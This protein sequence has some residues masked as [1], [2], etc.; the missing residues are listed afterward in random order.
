MTSGPVSSVLPTIGV[1]ETGRM[2]AMALEV[3]RTIGRYTV[4]DRLG[5]GGMGIVLRGR[6]PELD[7]PVAIK[8]ISRLPEGSA[9]G[10][11]IDR[12][13]REAR[14]AAVLTH[15]HIVT[16]YDVGRDLSGLPFIVME[17]LDGQSL[18]QVI[19]SRQSI[20][21]T[22]RLQWMVDL[23]TGLAYAHSRGVVHRDIKPANLMITRAG[24]LKIL[25]F[26]I[27]RL[28]D[29][30]TSQASL[31]Q[32]GAVLGTPRY[33]SPEQV[34]G[35]PA[36][37]RSDVFSVGVVLYELFTRRSTPDDGTGLPGAL[38]ARTD[39]PE[40][41]PELAPD[42]PAGFAS[43]VLK[44]L[45]P[46]P[47]RRYQSITQL[48]ADLRRWT[49]AFER[50]E[51]THTLV[52]APDGHRP[53]A[54]MD[55]DAMLGAFDARIGELLSD[56]SVE[57]AVAEDPA[58]M[59]AALALP[60]PAPPPPVKPRPHGDT[61]LRRSLLALLGIGALL[62][63]LTAWSAWQS[64]RNRTVGPPAPPADTEVMTPARP[65]RAN[66]SG[67]PTPADRDLRD[68]DPQRASRC[69][70]ILARLSIG[71]ELSESETSFLARSCGNR[72]R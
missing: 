70:D 49:R 37:E 61:Y 47:A 7:R 33:M 27:A 38:L 25:D 4:I 43:V 59:P 50:Q 26:G 34:A 24:M 52:H 13:T 53:A 44:A 29:E 11:A 36:D 72:S 31:T 64:T 39:S 2:S 12:F 41:L 16:I 48:A 1:P 54:S 51:E 67:A 28:T 55:L 66:R 69:S 20:P 9:A 14:A 18:A 17:L 68:S 5:A 10:R 19:E 45:E 8:V 60:R 32:T 40:H 65:A 58:P 63:V 71:D 46:N 22:R 23:C 6:D 21:Q 42:I 56:T 35:V 30:D 15:P 57:E 3:P 62:L